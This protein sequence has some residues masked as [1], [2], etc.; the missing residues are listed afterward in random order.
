MGGRV[1]LCL[2]FALV[3]LAC[4]PD[5]TSMEVDS[6]SSAAEGDPDSGTNTAPP[7]TDS[8]ET[9]EENDYCY[10]REA[11]FSLEDVGG[12][13]G[14]FVVDG[15]KGGMWTGWRLAALQDVNGDGFSD[16][17]FGMPVNPPSG[18][19]TPGN[20]YAAFGTA[21]NAPSTLEGLAAGNGG[22][23]MHGWGIG[24]RVGESIADAGDVNG[25]GFG[26]IVIGMPD[27]GL[28]SLAL[29]VF[30][31]P[32]PQTMEL[33]QLR[34]ETG[35]GFIIKGEVVESE[36]ESPETFGATVGGAGDVNGDGLGDIIV[37]ASDWN[38][39][40]GKA[41]I[42]FGKEDFAEVDLADL[43]D[44]PG[45]GFVIFGARAGDR[46]GIRVAGVG[47]VNA[48]GLDDV[49]V[50]APSTDVGDAERVGHAYLVFGKAD[51]QWVSVFQLAGGNGGATFEGE[52][53]GDYAGTGADAGDV[54]GDGIDDLVVVTNHPTAGEYSGR[55]Y[56]IFGDPG[57]T[58]TPLSSIASGNGGFAIDA[59]AD[60]D[61]LQVAR[62][63]GDLD[64][65]GLGDIAVGAAGGD[66]DT[67]D[68]G[69]VYVVYGKDDGDVVS[70]ADV[71]GGQDGF[72][73]NGI[74]EGGHAGRGL[75]GGGDIDGDGVP[76]LVIGAPE[77]FLDP[78]HPLGRAYVVSGAL[79]R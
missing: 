23:A 74:E 36:W 51:D 68:T 7:S 20:A 16:V 25:D 53:E 33:S 29:V 57:L 45:L 13:L 76:D 64:G 79:L 38:D 69:R 27:N 21:D 6:G 30:G 28:A 50:S 40:A 39:D 49:V 41:Y 3:G 48:D 8:G 56:V 35:P 24:G 77:A 32:N 65:D 12:A 71:A 44:S 52:G 5:S 18:E 11:Q 78:L 47:D 72:V 75:D 1:E 61:S 63:I 15:P 2:C 9:G 22:F 19:S 43:E 54:N 60:G 58:T 42:V 4:G 59:E 31:G 46:L 37:G 34:L 10:P 26:D 73:I 17:A 55:A 62:G 14:G 66:G 67:C 70:L